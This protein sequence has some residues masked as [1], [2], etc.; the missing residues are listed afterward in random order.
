MQPSQSGPWTKI[1][2]HPWS[3]T[4]TVTNFQLARKTRW[5]GRRN[6][7][8]MHVLNGTMN[9]VRNSPLSK[10]RMRL[11]NYCDAVCGKAKSAIRR[12]SL[13]QKWTW[14]HYVSDNTLHREVR[15][16]QRSFCCTRL[17]IDYFWNSLQFFKFRNH[18]PVSSD[19]H[20][21]FLNPYFCFPWPFCNAW[22]LLPALV[23]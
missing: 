8:T 2:A 17:K 20:F 23:H 6:A 5:Q 1:I 18:L 3:S 10:N 7:S 15:L 13:S 14:T 19:V 16:T 9:G 12:V 22:S 4:C 21:V 11:S